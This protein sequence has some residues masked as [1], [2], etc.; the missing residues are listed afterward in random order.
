MAA[1]E[2]ERGIKPP[3]PKA[4]RHSH[5]ALA[6]A[7]AEGLTPAAASI[8]T[9]YSLSRISILQK[10]PAF[11]ELVET[12]RKGVEEEYRDVHR[13]MASFHV[14]AVE[15][16]HERMVEREGTD[17]ELPHSVLLEGIKITAD[18][19]GFGPQTKSTQ[20][21]INV[22]MAARVEAARRRAGLLKPAQDAVL[23]L[24]ASEVKDGSD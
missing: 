4:L 8:R 7:L 9:G 19:T 14:D 23:D 21:N 16:L 2:V 17:E 6:R 18:R 1:L 5:H 13:A 10:T 24:P 20:V 11:A 3:E 22:N 12:Y 15:I